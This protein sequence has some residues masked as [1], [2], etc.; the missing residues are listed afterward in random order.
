MS[1]GSLGRNYCTLAEYDPENSPPETPELVKTAARA[2][3]S[4]FLKG[5]KKAADRKD[6]PF[7]MVQDSEVMRQVPLPDS[8]EIVLHIEVNQ[9]SP[10]GITKP[11]RMILPPLTTQS[12]EATVPTTN[13]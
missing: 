11:Y 12:Y 5:N 6:I 3:I 10:D 8:L 2:G 4:K 1:N 7:I 9:R 13:T